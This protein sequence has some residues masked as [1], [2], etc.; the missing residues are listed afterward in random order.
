MLEKFKIPLIS[1]KT[2]GA[3][4]QHRVSVPWGCNSLGGLHAP[5]Q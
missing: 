2:L 4:R 5:L 1:H 3:T